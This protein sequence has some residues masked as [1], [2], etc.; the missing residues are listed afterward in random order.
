[1]TN[2]KFK[3]ADIAEL[4]G[5]S[6]STVSFVLNGHAKKHRINEETVKKV[7]AIAFAHNY[8]P[9]IYA[10]ALKS[11]Q[12]YTAGL[13]IPDLA[14][15]G[16]ARIAKSLELLCRRSG[17]QL[18]IAS[19]EDNPEL[20]QQAIQSLVDRQV[21]VLLIA[22]SMTEERFFHQIK[23]TTPLI[24]FDRVIDDSAFINIKTDAST[25]TQQVVAKLVDG[26][27]ECVYIGG[28]LDLSPS[29]DRFAGYFAGLEQS[30]VTYN[31]NN[32]F[33]KDYQPS[34][35]YEMMEQVME[36]LGRRPEAIFTASYS[37]LEGVLRYLTEHDLLDTS[38]RLA[39]FDNYDILDCLPVKI[40]SVEQDCELIANA[41]FEAGKSLLNEPNRKAECLV[42]PAKIHSRR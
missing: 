39:T 31:P 21:D 42:F 37:L 18:L 4:A 40:D 14:N 26:V 1:M 28:Q 8:S 7:E 41:L 24:L 9:S 20:E 29:R 38:V 16:F 34:S 12:T 25:A 13:V 2:K 10:R 23:Q 36:K 30:G 19:S 27:S 3:L 15:M 11:K 33:N 6:K 5:V 22:T 32:V 35:G 17:Y